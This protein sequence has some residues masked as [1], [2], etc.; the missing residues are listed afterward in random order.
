MRRTVHD[1][2]LHSIVGGRRHR[3]VRRCNAVWRLWS[4]PSNTN[5]MPVHT[6]M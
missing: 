2:D 5:K 3:D 4:M 6:E 1:G